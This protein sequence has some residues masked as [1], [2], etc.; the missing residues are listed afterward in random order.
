MAR[1]EAESLPYAAD[2][3]EYME[4]EMWRQVWRAGERMNKS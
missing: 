1:D 2:V 4:L 3:P